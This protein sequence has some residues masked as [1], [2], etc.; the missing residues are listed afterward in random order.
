MFTVQTRSYM[1]CPDMV[2]LVSLHL[3]VAND[4][5]T[6]I[7]PAQAELKL[8]SNLHSRGGVKLNSS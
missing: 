1:F 2:S 6:K 8:N 7:Y 4:R 3:I 5:S